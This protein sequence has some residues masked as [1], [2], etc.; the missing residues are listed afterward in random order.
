MVVVK[1]SVG[2][3]SVNNYSDHFRP[4]KVR[5]RGS[6]WDTEE[7][8]IFIYDLM[9]KIENFTKKTGKCACSIMKNIIKEAEK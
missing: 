5:L 7:E 1:N 4:S 6:E 3:P 8:L 9:R 2:A